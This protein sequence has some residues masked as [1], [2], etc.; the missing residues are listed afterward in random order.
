MP[1]VFAMSWIRRGKTAGSV[2]AHTPRKASHCAST[3][4]GMWSPVPVANNSAVD[5]PQGRA[6]ASRD[7][8]KLASNG[9]A[10]RIPGLTEIL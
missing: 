4:G 10:V 3:S 8:V 2:P 6:A 7:R 1:A 5:T 9:F